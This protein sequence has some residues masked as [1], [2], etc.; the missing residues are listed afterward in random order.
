MIPD[1]TILCAADASHVEEL[2]IS[3]ATWKRHKPSLLLRP[4]L[5]GCDLHTCPVDPSGD[6]YREQLGPEIMAH[7]GGV[8]LKFIGDGEN[9][10]VRERMV[11]WFVFGARHV[12]TPY[13]LKLDSDCVATGNDNWTDARWFRGSPAIIASKWQYTKPAGQLATFRKWSDQHPQAFQHSM[14]EYVIGALGSKAFHSRMISYCQFGR[15]D[16]TAEMAQLAGER[17]PIPSQDGFLSLAAARNGAEIRTVQ[18]KN[19]GW[20]HVGGGGRRLRE[21]AAAAMELPQT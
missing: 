14:P 20:Q 7:P 10:P 17:L 11:S 8:K 15:T 13:Y 21:A 5:I 16:W 4:L 19:L 1:F 3:Y 18:M 6:W 2:R 12:E 9:W